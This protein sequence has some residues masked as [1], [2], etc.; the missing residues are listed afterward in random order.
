MKKYLAMLLI[1]GLLATIPAAASADVPAPGGP[2]D[3][4]FRIQN[5]GASAANCEFS[6]YDA[7]GV[8]KYTSGG[9]PAIAVGD[10]ANIYVPV[11]TS[12]A[13][14]QYAGVVTCDQEVAAVVNFSD[15]SSGASYSG[16]TEPGTTLFAPGLYD[17]FYNEY[18]D[19]VVQNASGGTINITLNIYEEGNT[20]PV[21]TEIKNNVP[22]NG[23]VTFEQEGLSELNTNQAYSGKIIGT[24]NIAAVVN[25]YGRA[26][27]EEKLYSYNPFPGTWSA[28]T[29]YAPIIEN[30]Y[31]TMNTSLVIQNLGGSPANVTITYSDGTV[32]NT[33]I[34]PGS[35]DSR[36]TPAETGL[37]SGSAG[38]VGAKV[39]CTNGQPIVAM[40]NAGNPMRRASTYTAFAEGTT[41]VRAP[42]A[43]KSYYNENSTIVCQNI[44]GG[45]TVMTIKYAGIAGQTDSPS[46]GV[47]EIH[48]FYQPAD[49]LLAS[50]PANWISSATITASQ[51]IVCVVNSDKN[52]APQKD[53]LKDFAKSYNGI[54]Q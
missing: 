16:V 45:P 39:E 34:A 11:D 36:Y 35:S 17:S 13:D 10:A 29:V 1:V 24:G 27:K 47:N 2:F 22:A 52:K 7:S 54:G 18:S 33:T 38:L 6:F 4:A 12:V 5:L 8:A 21:K 44:G 32:K 53:M 40:V 23:Y 43:M 19:V 9:L 42:I 26:G 46:K 51:P 25:I 48:Q 49:P 15:P 30:A 37:P 20:T 14:G 31:Y 28:T 3:T 50:A 41:T